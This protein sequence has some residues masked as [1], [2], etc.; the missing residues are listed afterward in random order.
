MSGR[1]ALKITLSEKAVAADTYVV[2]IPAEALCGYDESYSEMEDNPSDITLTW[3]IASSGSQYDWSFTAN[4]E[5]V[6]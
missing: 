4:P 5:A 3:T 2:N 6:R 1:R